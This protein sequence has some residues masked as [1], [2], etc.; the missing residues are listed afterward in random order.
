[1]GRAQEVREV[2]RERSWRVLANAGLL[3]LSAS[4]VLAATASAAPT[5][6]IAGTVT[7]TGGSEPIART[8]VCAKVTRDE[9]SV[10]CG[11]TNENGEYAISNLPPGEYRVRFT[12]QVGPVHREYAPQWYK[13]SLSF[14][15]ATPVQV[16]ASKTNNEVNASMAAA[17]NVSGTVTNTEGRP[18]AVVVF[19][20]EEPEPG[21]YE[22]VEQFANADAEGRYTIS[23]VGQSKAYIQFSGYVCGGEGC[24]P[25]YAQEF[26][27]NQM[28]L[29]TATPLL[30]LPGEH[31]EG[32]NAAMIE[33][34]H[35]S[36]RVVSDAIEHEPI[37]GA[38]V[39]ARAQGEPLGSMGCATANNN[40]EYTV[41]ALPSGPYTVEFTGKV[42]PPKGECVAAYGKQYYSGKAA[43]TEA[44][45]VS[46]SVASTTPGINAALFELSP[47]AP[48]NTAAPIL[49]GDAAAG[50]LLACSQGSWANKPTKLEYS[51][52]RDGAPI[53]GQSAST[54]RVQ[55]ADE[56]H[57]IACSV[58]ASNGAGAA[59][60]TSDAIGVSSLASGA[61]AAAGR[62]G[63]RHGVAT[64][65]LRCTSAGSCVG[66]LK[67]YARLK[68]RARSGHGKRRVRYVLIGTAS[69]SI[70]TGVTTTVD[71]PLTRRGRRLLHRASR[72]GLHIRL[73][74]DGVQ[75]GPLL[76]KPARARAG[77]LRQRPAR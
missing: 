11:E 74:G 35:I 4:L 14:S 59:S 65:R 64:V 70:A 20:W 54:Y 73:G 69:F 48:A 18:L 56:G 67:L 32:I 71:V 39:C 46:V 45:P 3:A 30:L 8:E 76:L 77:T 63:V 51:W 19:L 37:A 36:G 13:G 31:R 41:V 58:V 1:M 17:A 33:N 66:T 12:G 28:S 42:C 57:Q 25:V 21:V 50:G 6:S 55:S 60:A 34:G 38:Q 72:A 5:G 43:L 16:G 27:D 23:G 68:R 49:S 10:G 7:K 26:Y 40:G 75:S 22:A 61:L 15:G 53:A 9:P 24:P 29:A 62:A 52:L 2:A 44:T 47:I